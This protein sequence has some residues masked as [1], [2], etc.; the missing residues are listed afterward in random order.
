MYTSVKEA[1]NDF[2]WGLTGD[3]FIE[4][5]HDY[6]LSNGTEEEIARM[7]KMLAVM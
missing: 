2:F 3:E 7:E 5:A 6:V 4:E 1:L